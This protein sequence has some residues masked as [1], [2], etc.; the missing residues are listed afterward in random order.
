MPIDPPYFIFKNSQYLQIM[1]FFEIQLIK[2][3]FIGKKPL[4]SYIF[5]QL[6][7]YLKL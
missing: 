5:K 6:I 2:T 4:K 7:K 3:Y 1:A